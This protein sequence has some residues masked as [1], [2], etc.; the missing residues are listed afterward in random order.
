M[1]RQ[2]NLL[3]I[4][5][6]PCI[7]QPWSACQAIHFHNIFGT[8]PHSISK[9]EA[10][11]KWENPIFLEIGDGFKVRLTTQK[12]SAPHNHNLTLYNGQHAILLSLYFSIVIN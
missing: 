2:K 1:V 9:N 8:Q 4:S 11:A 12:K 6:C 10:K 7:C 3:F 5:N